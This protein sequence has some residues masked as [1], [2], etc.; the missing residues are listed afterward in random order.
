MR[1]GR[2]VDEGV[3]DHCGGLGGWFVWVV[4]RGEA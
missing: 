2:V 1:D 3:S 4:L